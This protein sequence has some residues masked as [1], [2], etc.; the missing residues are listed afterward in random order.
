MDR[1]SRWTHMIDSEINL[2]LRMFF[3]Y[4]QFLV[5]WKIGSG[6]STFR[7]DVLLQ[8]QPQLHARH[9][10]RRT[11]P[12]L[13]RELLVPNLQQFHLLMPL[14]IRQTKWYVMNEMI[15]GQPLKDFYLSINRQRRTTPAQLSSLWT[16]FSVIQIWYR[17]QHKLQIKLEKAKWSRMEFTFKVIR[18]APTRE[19]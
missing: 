17:E 11:S 1:F 16:W 12:H 6:T 14:G 9:L 3:G 5:L 13:Q 19:I 10:F 15:P 18:A 8:Q 4:W 7:R 2:I